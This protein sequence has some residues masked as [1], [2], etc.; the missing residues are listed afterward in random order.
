LEQRQL[1]AVMPTI[2]I[3]NLNVRPVTAHEGDTVILAEFGTRTNGSVVQLVD[4]AVFG[5]PGCMPLGEA[6]DR[7]ELRGNFDRR[8]G[9]ERRLEVETLTTDM[10]V[11]VLDDMR[12]VFVGAS[13][14]NPTFQLLGHVRQDVSAAVFEDYGNRLGVDY[15]LTF[16]TLRGQEV[17][18][19]NERTIGNPPVH[20]LAQ[21]FADVWASLSVPTSV[22]VGQPIEVAYTVGNNGPNV[23]DN[24]TL[25]LNG[26]T[27]SLGSMAPGNWGSGTATFTTDSVGM[28][29]LSG[30]VTS[31][32]TDP[33]D[34]NNTAF[35]TVDVQPMMVDLSVNIGGPR[36]VMAGADA[37]YH[38]MISNSG[39]ATANDVNLVIPVPVGATFDAAQSTG[40]WVEENGLLRQV[41]AVMPSGTSGYYTAVFQMNIV[42]ETTVSASV[43]SPVT[44]SNPANNGV[45]VQTTVVQAAHLDVMERVGPTSDTVV[46]NQKDVV[47][48]RFD[49]YADGADE[50][51]TTVVVGAAEGNLVNGIYTLWV[52]TDG[53]AVVDTI[54]EKNVFAQNGEVAFDNLTGGGFVVL[55]ESVVRF[56]VHGDV[57]ASPLSNVLRTA[58]VAVEG[59]RVSDGSSVAVNVNNSDQTRYAIADQGSLY[60]TQDVTPLREHQLQLGTLGDT[61][62]RLKFHAE[63]ED[64]DVTKFQVCVP[65][66]KEGPIDRFELYLPGATNYF[67]VASL[68]GTGTDVVPSGYAA[69]TAHM[70]SQQLVVP[71]GADAIVL[72]KPRLKSDDAG[73]V[74]GGTFTVLVYPDPVI[75]VTTGEGAIFARGVQSS[76]NLSGNDQ[77]TVDDGE[78]FLGIAA[79][80]VN[81]EIV[82]N[83]EYL[84][85]AKI[86]AIVNANPDAPGTSIV[87]G[88]HTSA[89]AKFSSPVNNNSKDGL[90]KAVIDGLVFTIY[91][92]NVELSRTGFAFYNKVDPTVTVTSYHVFNSSGIELTGSTVTGTFYVAF[93]SLSTGAVNTTI[94]PGGDVTFALL[95]TVTNAKVNASQPS[96]LSVAL[97]SFADPTLTSFGVGAGKS[98]IHWKSRDNARAVDEFFVEY[99]DTQVTLGSYQG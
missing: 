86:N 25:D 72:A 64:V 95:T 3:N 55:D 40:G 67:A 22:M 16:R 36:E 85:G 48:D 81:Q 45:S 1:L 74:A 34:A 60:V 18:D 53:N 52:D 63:I 32:V 41:E 29:T 38:I 92:S 9:Y 78:V 93:D 56:E 4:D 50:L 75:N 99:P 2:T 23:A 87:V 11:A 10:D 42:G 19:Q 77:D 65:L 46:R 17:P 80:G 27:I 70:Q 43:Y 44:D 39:P 97:D 73:G 33:N 35:A 58:L 79:P 51:V 14:S 66:G 20:T 6:F 54:L 31:Q 82:S 96:A 8:P 26:S 30:F 89:Q 84:V 12:S 90:D 49:V 94:P 37:S 21:P 59:E 57:A 76:R 68:A 5:A 88:A 28:Y 69:F 7:L 62:V 15:D 61:V 71:K 91:A 24:V 47:F 98:H 83:T 13:W